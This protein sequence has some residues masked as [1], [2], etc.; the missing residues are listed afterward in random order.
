MKKGGVKN[1]EVGGRRENGE[2]IFLCSSYRKEREL[3]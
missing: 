2:S 3:D 1:M